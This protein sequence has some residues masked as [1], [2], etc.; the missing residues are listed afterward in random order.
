[1]EFAKRFREARERAGLTGSAL[2]R[3]KYTVSYISQIEAGRRKPSQEALEFFA[4]RL[5]VSPKYLVTGIPEGVEVSLHYELE[6]AR[7]ALTASRLA[8]AE[9]ALYSIVPQATEYNLPRVRALALSILGDVLRVSGRIREAIEVYE[10]AL[11]DEHLP[12]REA[13]LTVGGLA[14]SYRS[15]GD[16]T[17]AAEVIEAFLSRTDGGPL[18]PAVLT[19]LHSVLVSIYFE[20]GDILRAERSA[21]RALAAADQQTPLEVRAVAYWHAARVFAET[22]QWEEAL[23]LATRARVL[24]EEFEDRRRVARLHNAY[25]FICLETDPPRVDEAREHLD[26]AEAMLVESGAPGDLSNVFAERG[27]LS[28]IEGRPEE[29][30][31]YAQRALGEAVSDELDRARALF[32]EGRALA[33]LDRTEEARRALIEAAGLFDK[34]GARQQEAGCWR[35]LGE[36]DL[37]VGDLASAVDSLRAGLS[38]LEPRRSRA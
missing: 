1:M 22:K 14:R 21:R 17:Y 38:A 11:A 18:D 29:A 3:P 30:L 8:E 32:L 23:D 4:K 12:Q 16:L 36:L 27:R 15:A 33:M 26:L 24:M 35:E 37:A 19:D 28:L 20:R 10:E 9:S 2:A 25:A 7:E 31:E 13:G 6:G 5:G 34:H